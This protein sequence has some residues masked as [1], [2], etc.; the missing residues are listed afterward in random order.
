MLNGC[1]EFLITSQELDLYSRER[2]PNTDSRMYLYITSTITEA[3]TNNMDITNGRVY[4]YFKPYAFK[5]VSNTIFQPGLPYRGKLKLF[6]VKTNVSS[7]VIEVCYN[8]ALKRSWNYLNLEH[9]SNFSV[10]NDNSIEFFILPLK[11]SIIHIILK[12]GQFFI[13]LFR[14]TRL[15]NNNSIYN[16]LILLLPQ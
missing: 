13:Y 10:G 6:N 16:I 9:C 7:D 1:V 8:L 3:G 4:I 11:S 2:I 5:F 15:K 12:V 14:D